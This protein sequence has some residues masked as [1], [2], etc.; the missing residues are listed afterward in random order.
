MAK[1][2]KN[3]TRTKFN[4]VYHVTSSDIL[5]VFIYSFFVSRKNCLKQIAVLD[6]S[7]FFSDIVL[8]NSFIVIYCRSVVHPVTK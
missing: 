5:K 7:F 4:S 1:N 2:Y 3:K 8:N 6:E